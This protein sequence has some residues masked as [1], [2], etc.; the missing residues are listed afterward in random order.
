MFVPYLVAKPEDRFSRDEAH[1]I[2]QL[3]CERDGGT[4]AEIN[5]AAEN[6]YL[7]AQTKILGGKHLH[8][9]AAVKTT[10]CSSKPNE[11]VEFA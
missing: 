7:Q 8:E 2:F 3:M 10:S 9:L 1:I 5:D 6:A 4:L 11:V